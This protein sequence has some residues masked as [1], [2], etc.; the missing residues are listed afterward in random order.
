M[1]TIRVRVN[2]SPSEDRVDTSQLLVHYLRDVHGLTGTPPPCGTSRCG[3]CMVLMDGM[4]VM[5]CTLLAVQA[6]GTDIET[7]EGVEAHGE[8]AIR[9]ALSEAGAEPCADC[10]AG[11]I[12][13][14]DEMLRRKV[15]PTRGEV[16]RALAGNRCACSSAEAFVHA[17]LMVAGGA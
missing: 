9:R 14:A 17:V 6:D 2:G 15:R 10:I 5:S 12:I 16:V 11:R 4:T 13:V 7:I 1:E 8:H 3:A